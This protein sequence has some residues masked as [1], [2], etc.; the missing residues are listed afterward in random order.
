MTRRLTVA[1]LVGLLA[2]AALGG[3]WRA[4]TAPGPQSLEARTQAV[5]A[6]LRC[7]TCQN[8][9]VA[10]SPSP[11]AR[12]MRDI[13]AEQ[14]E[15]GR[16]PAEVQSWFVDR[17][18]PWVLLYPPREGISWAVWLAPVLA[19]LAAAGLAWRR[20]G[21]QGLILDEA[22]RARAEDAYDQH[23][24]GELVAGDSPV[25]ERLA[26]ALQHL[27]SV[28]SDDDD[29]APA[30]SEDAERIALRQVARAFDGRQNEQAAIRVARSDEEPVEASRL[31]PAR[32]RTVGWAV[33]AVMFAVAV[34]VLLP[35]AL[36][37]RAVGGVPSGSVPGRTA[38]DILGGDEP[39]LAA[40]EQAELAQ[41]G[42]AVEA[43]PY[44]V[45]TRLTLADRLLAAGFADEA[46]VHYRQAVSARPDDPVIRLTL[47]VVLL[48]LGDTDGTER[49][50][51]RVL[52]DRPDHP[53]ALLLAGLARVAEGDPQGETNLRRFVEI[54]P[55]DHPGLGMASAVLEEEP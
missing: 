31:A 33:T 35:P 40:V 19:F 45:E 38:P 26:V 52:D 4:A 48:Q 41:L 46:A 50:A 49:H 23:R 12:G 14:L 34:V 21:R 11:M 42:D 22:D 2:A 37:P 54:A 1:L 8:L 27:E 30:R 18:G 29:L 16:S 39:G 20:L 55:A 15:A 13:I 32:R 28:R 51:T 25:D 5:A 44:D 47:A 6:T 36:G 53:E 17:Y 43:D 24:A 3:V 10:D 7:P 9:A